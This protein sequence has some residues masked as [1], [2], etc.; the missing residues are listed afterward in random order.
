MSVLEQLRRHEG[1]R[2]EPY[3]CTEGFLTIGYGRNLDAKGISHLE[4]VDML[5]C[6]IE[7]TEAAL[8][9][10]GLLDG[11]D[12][13]RGGVLVN[14]AFQL[15]INGLLKFEN[16]LRLVKEGRFEDASVEMLDSKWASQTP[17]RA[18]ELSQQMKTGVFAE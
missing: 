10:R 16:T 7:E 6:D 9:E 5:I 14:M 12:E 17:S 15:G 13:A 8:N 3:R 11:L 4:A 2:L 18:E 1:L